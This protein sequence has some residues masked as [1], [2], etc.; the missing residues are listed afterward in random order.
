VKHA[1]H[2][3]GKAF[4]TLGA[5]WIVCVQAAKVEAIP[6]APFF[7]VVTFIAITFISDPNYTE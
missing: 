7:V 5:V 4:C 6:A 2:G 1:V 3:V